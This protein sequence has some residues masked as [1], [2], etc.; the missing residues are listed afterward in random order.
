MRAL[1]FAGAALVAAH[2]GATEAHL[3]GVPPC[4]H[5]QQPGTTSMDCEALRSALAPCF[6]PASGNRVFDKT[7]PVSKWKWEWSSTAPA[8]CSTLEADA[9]KR[10]KEPD[11][12]KLKTPN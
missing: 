4:F 11:Y 12:T 7:G 6:D 2:A 5:M 9:L 1:I 8:Q 3:K 10:F